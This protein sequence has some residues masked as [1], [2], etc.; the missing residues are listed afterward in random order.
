MTKIPPMTR[1]VTLSQG[2]FISDE[3]EI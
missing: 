2:E 1:S 3:F